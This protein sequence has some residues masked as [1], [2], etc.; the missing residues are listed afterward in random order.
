MLIQDIEYIPMSTKVEDSMAACLAMALRY[1]GHNVRPE[2]V[3]LRFGDL[4]LSPEFQNAYSFALDRYPYGMS[5]VVACAEFFVNTYYPSLRIDVV[6]TTMQNVRFSY[7]KRKIPLILTGRF[8]LVSGETPNSV[9]VVG[10][11][12]NYIVVH[13]PRGNAKAGYRDRHGDLVLYHEDILAQWV[14]EQGA[15]PALRIVSPTS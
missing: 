9:I 5:R 6:N 12:D 15:I 4:F 2:N 14:G 1:H 8:P 13:D 10:Y 3:Y 7:V 11:V